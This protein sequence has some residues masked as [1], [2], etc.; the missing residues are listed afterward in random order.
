MFITH[1]PRQTRHKRLVSARTAYPCRHTTKSH[2]RATGERG[3]LTRDFK[4]GTNEWRDE[5]NY[6]SR[7]CGLVC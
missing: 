4:K 1:P 5:E 3:R 2:G 6:L 7:A